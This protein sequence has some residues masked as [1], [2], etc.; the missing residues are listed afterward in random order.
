MQA[1]EYSNGDPVIFELVSTGEVKVK[2]S[3]QGTLQ[4]LAVSEGSSVPLVTSQNINEKFRLSSA[5]S[6]LV[7]KVVGHKK[8]FGYCIEERIVQYADP[9]DD[10]EPPAVPEPNANNLVAQVHRLLKAQ[11]KSGRVPVLEPDVDGDPWSLRYLI[12]DDDMDFEEELAEKRLHSQQTSREKPQEAR[13][14]GSAAPSVG[15]P[16][17]KAGAAPDGASGTSEAVPTPP[18]AAE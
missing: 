3:S 1:F 11:A 7:L 14:P 13:S 6:S 17:D 16:A 15:S 2:A 8:P 9:L 5:F 12:D 10:Q 4:L 18:L